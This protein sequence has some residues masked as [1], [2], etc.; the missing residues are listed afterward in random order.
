[1]FIGDLMNTPFP[2]T[3]FQ[4]I[5]SLSVIEHE[6]SYDRFAKEVSRLLKSGGDCFCSFDYAEPKIKTEGMKL[7]NLEWNILSKDDVI[8]LVSEMEK[9]GLRITSDIDWKLSEAVI[10]PQYCS[11]AD[12]SYTFC[13]LHF[14]KD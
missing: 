5:C 14:K 6:I 10:N 2:D 13:I 9:C 12:V 11:P 8:R 3:E 7:F 1:Y 4:Q